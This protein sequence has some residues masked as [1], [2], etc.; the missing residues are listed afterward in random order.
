MLARLRERLIGSTLARQTL[1]YGLSNGISTAIL[2]A[3]GPV[4]THFLSPSDYGIAALF[5]SAFAFSLPL[6][7]LG[8]TAALRRRYYQRGQYDYPRYVWSSAGLATAQVVVMTLL[9]AALYPLWGTPEVGWLWALAFLPWLGGRYLASIATVL[10]Q[11]RSSPLGVGVLSWAQSL[12]TVGTTLVL[13][14]GFDLGWEGRVGGQTIACGAVGIVALV[15]MRRLLEAAPSFRWSLAKDAVA[16]GLPG[17]PYSLLDRS[18]QY[19]DRVIIAALSGVGPAG[20]YALGAQLSGLTLRVGTAVNL[21]WQPWLFERLDE[22]TSGSRR[23]VV[24]AFYA[25]AAGFLAIAVGFWLAVTWLFPIVIGDRYA[26]SL[27]FLPWLCAGV[28]FR[29][30][31]TLLAGLIL[32]S[33]QTKVLGILAAI[34]AAFHLLSTVG[35]VYLMGPVG[36]AVASCGAY[37]LRLLL[38]WKQSRRLVPL[39]GL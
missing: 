35:L 17:V 22:D 25:A 16:Y 11:V 23:R 34:I 19:A 3:V 21:A 9:L 12:L 13:V 39:R 27:A 37:A 5:G 18:M 2:A 6:V 30:M 24:L 1:A 38:I 26:A 36:G 4:L 7:G 33:N 32:Y 29:G 20:L 31:S 14:V 10:Y 15:V 28:A 8:A